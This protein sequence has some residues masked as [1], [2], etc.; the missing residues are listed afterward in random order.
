ML[1]F[2]RKRGYLGSIRIDKVERKIGLEDWLVLFISICLASNLY[3]LLTY[4]GMETANIDAMSYQEMADKL[5]GYWQGKV[6]AIVFISPISRFG[7]FPAFI[8]AVIDFL[9]DVGSEK[10]FL[11]LNTGCLLVNFLLFW[12]LIKHLGVKVRFF[13]F[14]LFAFSNSNFFLYL[15][16]ASEPIFMVIELC[17]LL[18]LGDL[19]ETIGWK[20]WVILVI[21][22]ILGLWTRYIGVVFFLHLTLLVIRSPK[23]KRL[24]YIGLVV[25]G[26][27]LGVAVLYLRSKA[28]N[29]SYTE[30]S[31]GFHLGDMDGYLNLGGTL[32]SYLFPY[33]H[34]HEWRVFIEVL[35]MGVL[36][37]AF[38]QRHLVK[39]DILTT[40]DRY[41]EFGL[42]CF[43]VLLASKWF[44]ENDIIFVTRLMYP[45]FPV[46]LIKLGDYLENVKLKN[47]NTKFGLAML[48]LIF[49]GLM[50]NFFAVNMNFKMDH[51]STSGH[52]KKHMKYL[53][54]EI[55]K[56]TKIVSNASYY[57]YILGYDHLEYLPAQVLRSQNE[58]NP[59]RQ[60]Q[61]ENLKER[62][63]E[64]GGHIVVFFPKNNIRTEQV[65]PGDYPEYFEQLK[66]D[67][68]SKYFVFR[69]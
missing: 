66:Q 50:L 43:A 1:N 5:V 32:I 31:V 63:L 10:A 28:F 2:R 62:S 25:A 13:I 53:V 37:F 29:L 34:F 12:H 41:L 35:I 6:E 30:R 52:V 56:N 45:I 23:Q 9:L 16:I 68:I 21:L 18:L 14:I 55:P 22:A 54:D 4:T 51:P 57:F 39:F 60:K 67:S 7:F 38:Q 64:A 58:I 65:N 3:I 59:H 48:V 24:G 42:I 46:L 69:R 19:K 11:M 15:E 17:F 8:P 36:Y 47:S 40:K 26:F 33:W 20:T 61:L 27:I 44:M 49:I